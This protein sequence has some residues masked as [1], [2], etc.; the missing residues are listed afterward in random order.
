VRFAAIADWADNKE[1]PVDFMCDELGVSRSGYYKWRGQKP[2]RRARDNQTLT[3]LMVE[4]SEKRNRPGVRRMRAELRALGWRIGPTRTWR[5]MRAAGLTGR[6]PRPYKKT[7]VQGEKPVDAP[8][9]IGREFSADRPDQKWCGDITYIKTWDGWAYMA[10]VIDLYSRKLVGWAV[11]PHMDVSLVI[12]A[13][14]QAL[15]SRRPPAN[16]IFHSDRGSQ[17]TSKTIADHCREHKVLRSLG[18]TGSC[19]DNAVSESFNATLKKELIHTRP[20]PTVKR[21]ETEVFNWVETHYNRTR[22]HSYL[23]Y[24]TIDEFELGY[25]HLDQ[26]AA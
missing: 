15:E 8:D 12:A 16:V 14:D 17:Y 25:E 7:T 5:L 4:I 2:S 1:Y 18:R 21:V 3:R 11:A 23:G 6:H 20:W 19:F 10:T 26:L 24:L 22:R 13:L 9:R